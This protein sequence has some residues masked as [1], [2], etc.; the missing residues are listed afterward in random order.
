MKLTKTNISK[1][2][3]CSFVF[4]L[5]TFCLIPDNTNAKSKGCATKKLLLRQEKP[6]I[7]STKKSIHINVVIRKLLL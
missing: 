2:I 5:A 1:V 7:L 4:M 6:T 3:I